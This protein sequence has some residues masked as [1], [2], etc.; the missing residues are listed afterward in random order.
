MELTYQ[1]GY[2]STFESEALPGALPRGQN[3]P[4]RAP[5]G[6]YPEL[7]NGTAFTVRRAE[8]SR[9]W[10]YKIRPSV[11]HG[12]FEPIDAG[13]WVADFRHTTPNVMRWKPL[14][15]P[16]AGERVD[17][18]A[19]M[20]TF[21]GHGDPLTRKGYAIH[22]YTANADMGDSCFYDVDGDLLIVPERGPLLCTTELG[23]LHVAPGE[24]LILPRGL[25]ANIALP[26]GEARGYAL[27]V[28]GEHFR[29]PE[30]GPMGSNGLADA[31]H[32][33]APVAHYEDRACDGYRVIAR[34][35][36]GMYAATQSHSPFDAVAWHGNYAPYKYDLANFNAMGTVRFD[37]PDPSI[38]TV[39][40]A[41]YDDHGSAIADFVVFPGRWEVAEHSFRPPMYHRN[42]ATE[43]NGIVRMQTPAGGFAPGCYF[44]TPM[45]SAHGVNAASVERNFSM[46]DDQADRPNRI[47]DESL[48]VMF[49]SAL[50]IR[51]TEWAMT[52]PN[53]DAGYRAA[54][55]HERSHFTPDDIAGSWDE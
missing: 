34:M 42:S 14:P 35:G 28:Y 1:S 9:L 30:R 31:R 16:G 53:R 32:F 4:R 45:L 7:V 47:P 24:V 12:E 21:G 33:L 17:F 19:G 23:R 37:H 26:D 25:K 29:L 6:L 27:E 2:G 10:L 3:A 41:P 44:C 54:F 15:L 46:S 48:W 13:R 40:T 20:T 50:P 36:G 22:L 51:L 52:S 8:N 18:V 39:L 11:Q 38:H 43:F 5:Y 49:E 55:Q